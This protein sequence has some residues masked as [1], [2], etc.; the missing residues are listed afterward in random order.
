MYLQE[1]HLNKS[2]HEKLRRMGFN[3]LF[4]SSYKSG[5]RRGV[6]T[7]ISNKVHFEKLY[8]LIDKEGRFV[9]VRGNVEGKPVTLFNIYAPPGSNIEFYKKL[10]NIMV[11]ETHGVLICGGD[12]YI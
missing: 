1:T 6:A 2:E 7:L 10:I 9:Q 5:H 3:Q 8:E 4:L 12:L 11:K